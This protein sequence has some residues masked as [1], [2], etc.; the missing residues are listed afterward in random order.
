MKNNDFKEAIGQVENQIND[1][2]EQNNKVNHLYDDFF[3]TIKNLK[4]MKEE[5]NTISFSLVNQL[6]TIKS[7]LEGVEVKNRGINVTYEE[8]YRFKSSLDFDCLSDIVLKEDGINSIKDIEK[9]DKEELMNLVKDISEYGNKEL[10]NL[11]KD[12]YKFMLL[13]NFI[14]EERNELS[15][16]IVSKLATNHSI[17]N[18]FI[19]ETSLLEI[20]KNV[21]PDIYNSLEELMNYY[22]TDIIDYS[23]A[24]LSIFQ[25]TDEFN[26][27]IAAELLKE[28]EKFNSEFGISD[29]SRFSLI[30]NVLKEYIIS[31]EY[32]DKNLETEEN[33]LDE[34]SDL[35]ENEEI[36]YEE[37]IKEVNEDDSLNTNIFAK[38]LKKKK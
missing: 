12:E 1:F 26:D 14:L 7:N 5:L 11:V 3:N 33:T 21:A 37:E 36:Y 10:I 25:E 20:A 31:N 24:K 22:D 29:D 27:Y 8:F 30:E 9:Y 28:K 6:E 18:G 34:I 15:F 17:I 13:Y 38:R 16:S 19:N 2:L 4:E 23:K 35:D 32:M